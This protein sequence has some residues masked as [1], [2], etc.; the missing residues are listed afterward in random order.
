M[1]LIIVYALRAVG[2]LLIGGP[3]VVAGY[4][5]MRDDELEPYRGRSLRG[6]RP[7]AAALDSPSPR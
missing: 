1:Q 2:L 7:P 5:A 3:I 4:G 6:E